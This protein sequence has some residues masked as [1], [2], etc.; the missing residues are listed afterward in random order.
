MIDVELNILPS[1]IK[2][3]NVLKYENNT[4]MLDTKEEE[5]RKLSISEKFNRLKNKD[6]Q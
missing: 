2:E 4:Y 5:E 1:N 6:N 3:G